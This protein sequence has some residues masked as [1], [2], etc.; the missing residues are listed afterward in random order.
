MLDSVERP[1]EW[2]GRAA[3][4]TRRSGL[5]PHWTQGIIRR[6]LRLTEPGGFQAGRQ[7]SPDAA[8][9]AARSLRR[10]FGILGGQP[11]SAQDPRGGLLPLPAGGLQAGRERARAGDLRR[12]AAADFRRARLPDRRPRPLVPAV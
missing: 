9:A 5:T 1:L 4:W 12:R 8:G 10:D 3:C 11:D 7:A 2:G 6:R